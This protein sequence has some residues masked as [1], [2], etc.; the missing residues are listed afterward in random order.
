MK[1]R[2]TR[3]SLCFGI[4]MM[5][6]CLPWQP[7]LHPP[8]K[9]IGNTSV[10]PEVFLP[11][12]RNLTLCPMGE[13]H[14]VMQLATLALSFGTVVQSTRETLRVAN[15]YLSVERTREQ[16][17]SSS[18]WSQCISTALMILTHC[19]ASDSANGAA[20][21]GRPDQQGQPSGGPFAK[22]RA[23]WCLAMSCKLLPGTP[24]AACW[25]PP[26]GC[27]TASSCLYMA[28]RIESGS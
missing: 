25:P 21:D 5:T 20:D 12:A 13:R 2:E 27:R 8:A 16:G 1:Y 10:T 9:D 23:S 4:A 19:G 7:G 26:Q 22:L 3:V 17:L 6:T 11:R 28:L 24:A 18:W 14:G 15:Q